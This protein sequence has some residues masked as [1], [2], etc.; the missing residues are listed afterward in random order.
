MKKLLL[1]SDGISNKKLK[2][3]FL[4]LISKD[5][6][7]I[8]VLMIITAG[9]LKPDSPK[10][11]ERTKRKIIHLGIPR[12]SIETLDIDGKKVHSIDKSFDVVHVCGGNTFFL[13]QKIRESGFGTAIRKFLNRGGLYVG[14][15]AG[16]YVTCPSII[17]ADWKPADNNIVGMKNFRALNLVPFLITAHYVKMYEKFIR[18][19]AS[20]TN[21]KVRI[22]RDGQAIS[23]VNDKIRFVGL[24]KEVRLY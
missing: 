22:L 9:K 13:L 14:V 6:S 20:E 2:R 11:V 18:K 23:V 4:R 8:K 24:G 21:Y 15:S 10:R 7:K 5:A 3:E 16:S 1:T 12:K 17:A 19:G